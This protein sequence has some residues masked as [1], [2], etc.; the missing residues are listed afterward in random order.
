MLRCE[1]LSE[2]IR[3]IVKAVREALECVPPELCGDIYERGGA[4][5]RRR[6]SPKIDEH[7]QKET[8]LP[9]VK[10]GEPLAT[11]VIGAGKLLSDRALLSKVAVN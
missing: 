8:G 10:A 1:R 9:V 11:V 3:A 7:L 2:P 4:H 6:L 5:G